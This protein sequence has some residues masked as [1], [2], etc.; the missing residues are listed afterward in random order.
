MFIVNRKKRIFYLDFIRTFSLFCIMLFHFQLESLMRTPD[1]SLTFFI[2]AEV[3]GLNSGHLGSSLFLILSGAAQTVSDRSLMQYMGQREKGAEVGEWAD[4]FSVKRY[5]LKRFLAIFVPFY[6]VW[7]LA[8]AGSAVFMPQKLEGIAPWTIVLTALGLDG[9][10]YELIPNFYMTGEWFLGCVI[11]LYLI[12]PLL[13]QGIVRW[14]VRTG[15]VIAG[16]WIVM[17]T[18]TVVFPGRIPSD[19]LFYLRLPEFALGM[20]LTAYVKKVKR[21][22]GIGCGIAAMFLL[23]AGAL[24]PPF[25]VASYALFGSCVYVCLR[26]VGEHWQGARR[27]FIFLAEISYAIFLLHHIVLM[28]MLEK[29]F[30]TVN[31]SGGAGTAVFLIWLVILIAAGTVLAE[32][33]GRI[34]RRVMERYYNGGSGR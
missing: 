33:C 30:S 23:A 17:L 6:L 19:H 27:I 25:N 28:L 2:G 12:Y 9:Y 20:Y 10:L 8:M 14:P 7:L 31:L 4:T 34:G 21:R 32:V 5:Y 29:G 15:F 1:F 16:I 22:V 3:G 24:K 11:F 18:A 26:M 13:R